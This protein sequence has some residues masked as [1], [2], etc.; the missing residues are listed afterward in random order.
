MLTTATKA[1]VRRADSSGAA[2]RNA[3]PRM[4]EQQFIDWCD[5][6]TRAEWLDREV[7]MMAPVSDEHDSIYGYLYVLLWTFV[8]EH[9]LGRVLSDPFQVR[10]AKQRR[11]RAPDIMFVATANLDRI[12][13]INVEGPPDLIIEIISPD[14]Q[15]RDRREKFQE[16]EAAG[17]REYWIVDP[18]SKT[19]EFYGLGK[20]NRYALI[21]ERDGKLR[22]RVLPRFYIKPKWL[23]Q[24]ERPDPAAILRELRNA[25]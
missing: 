18:L 9:R 19:V 20:S 12:K 23:W 14:S 6:D 17:V 5:E 4:T 25:K 8:L 16:Y 2:A 22:S 24:P 11:R 7:V 15:S 10:L 3:L 1:R 13:R 21:V